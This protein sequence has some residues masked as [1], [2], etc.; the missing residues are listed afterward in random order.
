MFH[1]EHT[2]LTG[3]I[4]ESVFHVEHSSTSHWET[5]PEQKIGLRNPGIALEWFRFPGMELQVDI[6]NAFVGKKEKPSPKELAHALGPAIAVWNQIVDRLGSELSVVDQEWKSYSPKYGWHLKLKF[7]KRTIIYLGPCDRLVR[8]SLIL[9]DRAMKAARE[10]KPSA[11][12]TKVLNHAPR[13]PEGSGV[14]LM[15]KSSADVS[16]VIKLAAIKLA[17]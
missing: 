3:D 6:P 13:Y 5:S 17:N 9:G 11:K 16:S 14:V 8:V 1:V 12:L 10:S 7:K 2:R 4:A 15:P